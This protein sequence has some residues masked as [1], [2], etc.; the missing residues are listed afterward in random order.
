MP[1]IE[2]SGLF[3]A[4]K[5]MSKRSNILALP[6]LST[7]SAAFMMIGFRLLF[8]VTQEPEWPLINQSP[9]IRMVDLRPVTSGDLPQYIDV[10]PGDIIKIVTR[11]DP[12]FELRVR[13]I[14]I[15][16]RDYACPR[17]NIE[18]EAAGS[19]Y[20][21]LCG[22]EACNG[23]GGI[24]PTRIGPIDISAEITKLLYS[25]MPIGSSRFSAYEKFRLNGQGRLSIWLRSTGVLGGLK[26]SF[27][28][29]QPIW[30]RGKFGNWLH[31][32]S[33]GMHAGIDVF[34][35]KSGDHE[36]VLAPLEAM[37][38]GVF[39][40]DAEPDS[41]SRIKAIYLKSE[42][43]GTGGETLFFRILH[44]S[45]IMVSVGEHVNAG[46]MIGLTGHT[47]FSSLAQE[48]L[49]FEIRLSPSLFGGSASDRIE[50]TVPVN[51]YPYLLEW[52]NNS[53]N[54]S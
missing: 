52:W 29:R 32:T 11:D 21:V 3:E 4:L 2:H 50:D 42:P 33:Y 38:I 34:S 27:V 10:N 39:A 36:P 12:P 16:N 51:P 46:Q 22:M 20:P 31:R 28:I 23:T 41:P 7:V 53:L 45:E 54:H 17:T 26:G 43:M 30:T 35:S 44:L 6:I 19:V 37:V 14:H 49:H 1:I 9:V 15:E 48:H 25:Q 40:K 5:G 18:L 13:S 24:V 8:F 47:G